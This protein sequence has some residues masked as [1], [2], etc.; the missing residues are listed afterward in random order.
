MSTK[1]Q[2]KWH[3]PLHQR[4]LPLAILLFVIFIG[5]AHQVPELLYPYFVD[6]AQVDG[7]IAI[8][9]R[10]AGEN[11]FIGERIDGY[12]AN[13]CL[14]TD[15]AATALAGVQRALRTQGFSLVVYDCYRPQQ[16][17]DHFV[18]WAKDLS[19]KRTKRRYYPHVDKSRLFALGYIWERSSHSRGSTVDVTL[20]KRDS[21]SSWA[22]VD[23]GTEYDYFD[24]SSNTDS[25]AITSA[26]QHNRVLLH[27]A[28]ERGGFEN[29]PKEWWHYTLRDEPYSDH[30][31][32]IVVR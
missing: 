13:R 12:L 25:I 10:Y 4:T 28:M 1:N 14:L 20:L 2:A 26:Q 17:V 23:M 32:D 31:W 24:P 9:I 5:C 7:S 18:R 21:D 8:D 29:F 30:Y 27:G 3:N 16:A 19:D 6:L 15:I 22:T 11:N